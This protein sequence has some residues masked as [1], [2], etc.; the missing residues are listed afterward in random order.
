MDEEML[1]HFNDNVVEPEMDRQEFYREEDYQAK[2][3]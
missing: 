2:S 1:H 3:E